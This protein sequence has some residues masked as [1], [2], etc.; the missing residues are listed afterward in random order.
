VES[1]RPDTTNPDAPSPDAEPNAN[2]H[3]RTVVSGDA[4]TVAALSDPSLLANQPVTARPLL[5]PRGLVIFA[6]LWVFLSWMFLFGL[7]PPIQPQAASYGPTL[8]LLFTSIG[9]G[10][11]IA[12][13]LLRLSARP[14][15]APALQAIFDAFALFVLLQ[16]VIWPLR[17]VSSWT[18]PRMWLIVGSLA[19]A[20]AISAAILAA[21]QGA[22]D[23]RVRT[24]AMLVAVCLTLLPAGFGVATEWV[25]SKGAESANQQIDRP[26]AGG[27]PLAALSPI[28][29][30][31]ML[32]RASAPLPLDPSADEWA[33][34]RQSGWIAAGFWVVA[35]P[36]RRVLRRV[37][38]RPDAPL[39]LS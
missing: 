35:F 25:S 4:V 31:L 30:P 1:K 15:A 18:I 10:V 8:V 17:L 22:F 14:S 2:S 13:P 27:S 19:A 23:R 11:S 16:V 26:Q 29:G 28:S 32:S 7:R 33:L 5:V 34:L 37:G 3:V 9:V 20:L 38:S 6:A 12:W 36:L 21:T 39:P 24:G